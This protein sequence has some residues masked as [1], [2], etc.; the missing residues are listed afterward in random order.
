[1][2]QA[3]EGLRRFERAMHGQSWDNAEFPRGIAESIREMT[4]GRPLPG[5]S[6]LAESLAS[7][8]FWDGVADGVSGALEVLQLVREGVEIAHH[9]REGAMAAAGLGVGIAVAGLAVGLRI[10][11]GAEETHDAIYDVGKALLG[12]APEVT[13]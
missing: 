7:T 1:M 13:R 12:E 9:L 2:E 6:P 11:Q 8:D 4:R 10:H 5:D 3:I